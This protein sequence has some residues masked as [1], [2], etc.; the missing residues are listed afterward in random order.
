[1]FVVPSCLR[2]YF[3]KIVNYLLYL[4][5]LQLSEQSILKSRARRKYGIQQQRFQTEEKFS[6]QILGSHKKKSVQK[7]KGKKMNIEVWY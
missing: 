1:M 2:G 5:I 3:F 6:E 7:G 4:D